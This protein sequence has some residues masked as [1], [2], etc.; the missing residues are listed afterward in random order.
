[1]Y[2]YHYNRIIN[3]L[4]TKVRQTNY[5]AENPTFLPVK[6]NKWL[7]TSF[8]EI[9]LNKLLSK[10]DRKYNRTNNNHRVYT[11]DGWS[12]LD[13]NHK[14]KT[15]RSLIEL[16]PK[17]LQSIFENAKQLKDELKKS[18]NECEKYKSLFIYKTQVNTLNELLATLNKDLSNEEEYWDNLNGYADY[19]NDDCCEFDYLSEEE[20]IIKTTEHN[21]KINYIKFRIDYVLN[22]IKEI[23]EKIQN[24]TKPEEI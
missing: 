16:E 22:E 9:E 8:K 7:I 2:N 14:L 13:K 12:V 21:E 20:Q 24:L 11:Y 4:N 5:K 3:Q 23:N 1:M 10:I 19:P 6:N 17:V 15:I 18:Q